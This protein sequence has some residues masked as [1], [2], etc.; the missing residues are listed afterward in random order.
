ML[1][2]STSPRAQY[3]L[4]IT[5]VAAVPQTKL[6]HRPTVGLGGP[7]VWICLG[8]PFLVGPLCP[9]LFLLTSFPWA[10]GQALLWVWFIQ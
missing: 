10:L 1:G 9:T 6:G 5:V 3:S 4:I 2:L 8:G 7:L